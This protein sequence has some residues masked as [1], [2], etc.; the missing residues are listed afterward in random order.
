MVT[1]SKMAK[2]SIVKNIHKT[3]DDFVEIGKILCITA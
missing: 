1:I 3:K 2:I